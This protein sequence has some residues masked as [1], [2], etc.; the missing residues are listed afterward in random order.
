MATKIKS[1]LALITAW[2]PPV[3]GC[4]IITV[5]LSL[6]HNW[7]YGGDCHLFSWCPALLVK[8]GV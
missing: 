5:V 7:A 6:Y 3:L 2:V 1:A 8:P 4:L